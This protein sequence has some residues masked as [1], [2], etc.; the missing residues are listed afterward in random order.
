MLFNKAVFFLS[1]LMNL[2]LPLS[3]AVVALLLSLSTRAQRND[4]TLIFSRPANNYLESMPL[5][6]GRIGAMDFGGTNTSRIILNEKTLWSGGIQQSDN[7]SAHFYLPAIQQFLLK[8]D[9]KSA[10]ELLQKKFVSRGPGSGSG[11]GANG[12]YGCY[13]VLGNLWIKWKDT[14]SAVTSYK[15]ELQ[16]PTAM[17]LTSWTRAGSKY[18]QETFVSSYGNYMAV[19]ISSS[20]K[21]KI[22]LILKLSREENAQL[23]LKG[24][25]L[26]MQGQLPDKDKKGMKYASALS[27]EVKGGEAIF[28]QNEV[29]IKN[30]T[31]VVVYFSAATDYNITNP[32]N[33]LADPL[34]AALGNL[35]DS[36]RLSYD[37][38]RASHQ[39]AFQNF[40]NRTSFTLAGVQPAKQTVAGRLKAYAE[41]NADA[42]LPVLYYNFGKYLFISSSRAGTLPANLQGIWAP[43]YQT[44]WNADYH[45]N[46]NVEMIYWPA[47]PMG[48]GE[49]ADPLFKY[50][51]SLVKPGEKTAKAYYQAPGWVAHVL[52][53]PWQYTSPGEGADWGSTLTGGA[54][55]CEHIWEH[56]RY[57]RDKDFLRKYYPVLKGSA[58]FLSSILIQEPRHGWLVT[59][60]SNSPEHAYITPEGFKGN[61]TMG[62]TI[63]M[64]IC[65]ETFDYV[66]AAAKILQTDE[67]WTNELAQKRKLLAPLQIGAR[68]DINEWLE[69]WADSEPKHR[70]VSHLYGLHP[71]DE[72]T[73]WDTPEIAK[74]ARETLTQRGD[75]GTGWSEAW[76]INFWAR[77][78]DGDHASLLIKRLL[79]PVPALGVGQ[80]AFSGGTFPNLFCAHPPFQMDGN[81]GGAAGISEMLVQSHGKDQVIRL[82]PALPHDQAWQSGAVKGFRTRGAFKVDFKWEKGKVQQAY[83]TALQGGTCKV[84]LPAGKK[85]IGQQGKLLADSKS[86]NRIAEF[87]TSKGEHFQML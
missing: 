63:D 52:A 2:K 31:T 8:G 55:L 15:R 5:G 9:N 26:I 44:P 56:Y 67:S 71:Y 37:Q 19:K 41:G 38:A 76:K 82:L 69:D 40:Y 51:E 66:I 14:T 29:E 83:F 57:T 46:I 87:Q 68:G 53:N 12:E 50:T 45:L 35:P 36:H 25:R 47:E 80:T 16:L 23:M 33:P 70:H 73:P 27:A 18:T 72:I 54:W 21:N 78:G 13:Q 42:Q 1:S 34:K 39:K 84:L 22:N 74:A 17:G 61:T 81:M 85:I 24:D 3:L 77:L 6:N 43:E 11:N 86:A 32:S 59:A 28:K 20:V 4:Q 64:Q 48:L 65:R 79:H 7:D 62:P 60:P 30:A 58:E 49:L 10:Q 75:E